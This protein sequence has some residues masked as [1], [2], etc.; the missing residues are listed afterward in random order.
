M[1]L[2]NSDI[3]KTEKKKKSVEKTV[4]I[5]QLKASTAK[6]TMEKACS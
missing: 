3:Y 2:E 5:F 1:N 6:K 4:Q